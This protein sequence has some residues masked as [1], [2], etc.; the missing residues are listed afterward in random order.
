MLIVI[1]II[2]ILAAALIPRLSNA[3]GRSNDTARKADLRQVATVI[4]AYI[5]DKWSVPNKQGA[6][7]WLSAELTGAGINAVP[8]D[9]VVGIANN[10]IAW[11]VAGQ[12]AYTPVTKWWVTSGGFV[13]M[14]RAETE[15]WA[16][17]VVSGTTLGNITW[18]TT[19]ESIVPC[20]SFSAGTPANTGGAC[21]YNNAS[22]LRYIIAY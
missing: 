6:L 13:L 2:G 22:Q 10:G 18:W 20:T 11:A 14:A 7:T 3:R 16:N 21:T 12:Y 5:V 1:V 4:N 8:K 9:P 19:I 15:G 17:R